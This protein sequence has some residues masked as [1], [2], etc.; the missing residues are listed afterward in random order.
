[1]WIIPAFISATLLGLYDVF[2][3]ISLSG[4]AVLPVLFLNVLFCCLFL[5]PLLI[6]SCFFPDSVRDTVFSCL[7]PAFPNM[8]CCC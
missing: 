8:P 2:K 7:P 5:S 1:M 4:N 6:L 3:K